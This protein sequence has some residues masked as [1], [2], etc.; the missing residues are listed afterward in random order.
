MGLKTYR[1]TLMEAEY[2]PVPKSVIVTDLVRAAAAD[3]ERL[4]VVGSV[5]VRPAEKDWPPLVKEFPNVSMACSKNNFR[6]EREKKE[7]KKEKS[8]RGPEQR[9]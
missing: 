6:G 9:R 8:G 5:K 3:D 2:W 7:E 4:L 1:V